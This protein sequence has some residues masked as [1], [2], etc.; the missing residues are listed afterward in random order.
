[1]G[2]QGHCVRRGPRIWNCRS[3]GM[4]RNDDSSVKVEKR[5]KMDESRKRYASR[6]YK[7]QARLAECE[8]LDICLFRYPGET[9]TDIIEDL[10]LFND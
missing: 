3:L 2:N 8:E 5:T 9:D 6:W 4:S 10:G 7:T 1:M